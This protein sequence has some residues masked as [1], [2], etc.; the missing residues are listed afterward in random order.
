MRTIL[1]ARMAGQRPADAVHITDDTGVAR[2]AAR[3]GFPVV[4]ASPLALPAWDWRA[5]RGLDVVMVYTPPNADHVAACVHIHE[6]KP[7]D[8]ICVPIWAWVATVSWFF[9]G[10]RWS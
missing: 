2:L 8:L 9:E 6:A 3:M 4:F 1:D 7:G 5:L 10:K